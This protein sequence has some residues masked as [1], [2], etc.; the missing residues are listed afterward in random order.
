MV[1]K[2]K[3]DETSYWQSGW[4]NIFTPLQSSSTLSYTR[5]TQMERRRNSG[6]TPLLAINGGILVPVTKDGHANVIIVALPGRAAAC[7]LFL[8]SGVYIPMMY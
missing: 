8:M 4:V 3:D 6:S 5:L 2:N 7:S 1:C